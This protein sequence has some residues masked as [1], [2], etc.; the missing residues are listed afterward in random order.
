M[1]ESLKAMVDWSVMLRP[2]VRRILDAM[3]GGAT[4]LTSLSQE[5]GLSKSALVPH[6]K[7]LAAL[8][9]VQGERVPTSTGAEAH[10]RLRDVSLHLSIDPHRSAAISW[11]SVGSWTPD[12]PLLGQVPQPEIRAELALLLQ[13]L[14]ALARK[15][16]VLILFGSAARGEATWKSDIDLLALRDAADPRTEAALREAQ[17]ETEM[18]TR[19]KFSIAF[20]TRDEWTAGRKRLVQE[21]RE[22]GMVVWAARGENAPWATLKRYSA[23][24]I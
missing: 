12:A 15:D 2:A 19:H 4:T 3:L 11:A 16:D 7:T 24:R 10:Y 6:L 1:S 21:A 18:E 8:G 5:T 23:I 22:E 13:R 20:V 9:V 14:P 17:Y